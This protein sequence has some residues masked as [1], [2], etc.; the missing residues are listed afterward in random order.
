MS[1]HILYG[2]RYARSLITEAVLIEGGIDYQLREIDISGN[3]HTSSE[4]LK[5]NPTGLVPTLVTPEGE[6]LY[7]CPAINLFLVD[8]TKSSVLHQGLMIRIGGN[9]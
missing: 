6:V 5:I 7:E 4:Y 9:S 3:E 2:N 8:I 1:K